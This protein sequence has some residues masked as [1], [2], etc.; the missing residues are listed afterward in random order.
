M[1]YFL[2]TIAV[3]L[4]YNFEIFMIM[5]WITAPDNHEVTILY[6]FNDVFLLCVYLYLSKLIRLETYQARLFVSQHYEN[7]IAGSIDVGQL[8]D[9]VLAE[10]I[11]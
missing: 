10:P 11:S 5:I 9:Q 3:F 2:S 6:D 4:F 1:A 7:L 8:E